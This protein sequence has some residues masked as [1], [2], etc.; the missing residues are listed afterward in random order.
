VAGGFADCS[1][2]WRLMLLCDERRA[3]PPV[4]PEDDLWGSQDDLRPPWC[5]G[6]R[7][8]C[9]A[10]ADLNEPTS[11]ENRRPTAGRGF[12][13]LGATDALRL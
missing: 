13:L 11:T 2:P 4:T 10:D 5:V 9:A 6:W 1:T 8:C 3:P 7:C 12:G